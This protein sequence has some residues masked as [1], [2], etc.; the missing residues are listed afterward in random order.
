MV[1]LE[2]TMPATAYGL[3][4]FLSGD[5]LICCNAT[6]PRISATIAGTGPKQLPASRPTIATIID[7]SASPW[8]GCLFGRASGGGG[9]CHGAGGAAI[10]VCHAAGGACDAGDL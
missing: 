8:A 3:P 6:N 10:G 4:V 9:A 7:A 2:M 5:F 1:R